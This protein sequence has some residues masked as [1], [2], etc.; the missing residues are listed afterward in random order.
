MRPIEWRVFKVGHCRQCERLSRKTA[1]W[2]FCEFPALVGLIEHPDHGYIL[3]DTGYSTKFFEKTRHFPERAYRLATPVSLEPRESLVDQLADCGIDNRQIRTIVLSHFHADHIAGVSDFP[4]A[5][6]VCARSGWE[7]IRSVGRLVGVRRGLI[8][9]LLPDDFAARASFIEDLP[10]ANLPPDLL[11]FEEGFDLLGNGQIFAVPLPGHA[12]GQFGLCFLAPND[13]YVFLAADAAWSI[14]AVRDFTLPMNLAAR[15]L[16]HT[17]DYPKSL[18][19]LHLL[20]R[21]NKEVLIVPSH[22]WER[23]QELVH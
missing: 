15:L 5:S 16:H 9:G 12:Q 4:G 17:P 10:V 19:R 14:S 13:R 23:E 6:I 8:S 3:F 22:C 21:R 11:P 20:H 7:E 2:R 18:H 1:L